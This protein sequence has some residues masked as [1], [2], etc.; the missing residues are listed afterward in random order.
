MSIRVHPWFLFFLLCISLTGY[1]ASERFYIGTYTG[2]GKADGIYTG[3]L[4]SD[5]GQLTVMMLATKAN[6]PGYLALSP[7]R[8]HLYAVTSDNGGS[9]E[10]FAIAMIDPVP[11]STVAL[12]KPALNSLNT[13]SSQGAGPCYLSVDPSGKNVLV[14][15]YSGGTIACIRINPDGT[16]L[17]STSSIAFQGTGPNPA[18][19]DKPHAHFVSTDPTGQFVYACD[20][21][22]DHVWAYRFDPVAGA[23]GPPE[24]AQATVPPGSGPR[25]LAFSLNG[26]FAY[27]NGEMGRNITVFHRDKQ[28]GSLTP[29]QTL[30]LVPGIAPAPDITTAEVVLHPSGKWLYVSSRGDDI[31]AVFAIGADGKLSFIQDVP[32]LVKFPRGFGIDPTGR[33]LIAAGQNDGK[34]AVLAIDPKTGKLTPTNNSANVPAAICVIFDGQPIVLN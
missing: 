24:P 16:L 11:I 13:V 23:F 28:T 1:S 15:N 20:L 12:E 34:L 19:Q 21:G 3:I 22:T 17:S 33:W 5:S 32:A 25:H 29:I 18:R 9:V 10:A 26:D 8:S 4:D 30:P 14:A 2:P 27:V 6:N 31:I 7:D